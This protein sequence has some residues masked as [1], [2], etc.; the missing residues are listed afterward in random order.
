MLKLVSLIPI[1]EHNK[2]RTGTADTTAGIN[3]D[4]ANNKKAKTVNLFMV[5]QIETNSS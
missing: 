2:P 5:T 3:N 4:P 1:I